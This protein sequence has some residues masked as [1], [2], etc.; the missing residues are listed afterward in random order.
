MPSGALPALLSIP[1]LPPPRADDASPPSLLPA[2]SLAS[3]SMKSRKRAVVSPLLSRPSFDR[4]QR[5]LKPSFEMRKQLACGFSPNGAS[6]A[7]VSDEFPSIEEI[8]S[9]A[10]DRGLNVE[11]KSFGLSFR[12]TAKNLEGTELGRAESF[13]VPWTDGW[14]LHLEYVRM[15]PLSTKSTERPVLGIAF[16]LGAVAIR[17]GYDCNCTKAELLAINDCDTYHSKARH[18]SQSASYLV[19]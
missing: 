5:V 2:T 16:L 3:A 15:T 4:I 19:F 13:V 18:E 17:H 11:A 14:I 8:I 9:V 1:L 6:H 10:K 7:N 12:V